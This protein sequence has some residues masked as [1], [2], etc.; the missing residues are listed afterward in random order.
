[1]SYSAWELVER[2]SW[3]INQRYHDAAALKWSKLRCCLGDFRQEEYKL[4]FITKRSQ[5]IQNII[6][7]P[8]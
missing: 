6:T 2:D 8:V 7:L 4:T 1:M 5:I 3:K